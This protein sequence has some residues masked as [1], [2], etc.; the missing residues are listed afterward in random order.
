MSSETPTPAKVKLE[1]KIA[2]LTQIPTFALVK[3]GGYAT[4]D[5]DG[6]IETVY[7]VAREAAD[8]IQKMEARIEQINN[9]EAAIGRALVLAQQ[10]AEKIVSA[11]RAQAESF[12]AEAHDEVRQLLDEASDTAAQLVI[13]GENEKAAA[14]VEGERLLAACSEVRE[15]LQALV[16]TVAPD[17]AVIEARISAILDEVAPA[18]GEEE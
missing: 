13:E 15:A 8:E 16:K 17:I 11:A 10:E 5:V 6:Y 9:A 7:A 3:R 18:G 4:E 14:V 1:D 12:L 2:R